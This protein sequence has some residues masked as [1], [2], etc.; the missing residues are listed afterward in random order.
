LKSKSRRWDILALSSAEIGVLLTSLALITGSI[1][2]RP[3]WYTWWT[4]D[5]RL[6]TTLVLW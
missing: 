1:W 5:I 2:A 3:I 4:W 6:T